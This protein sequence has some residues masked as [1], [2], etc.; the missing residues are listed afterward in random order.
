MKK[1]W[2]LCSL[3]LT[4]VGAYALAQN[5]DRTFHCASEHD[6]QHELRTSDGS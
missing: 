2:I 3:S 1:T 5:A 6:C 4:V